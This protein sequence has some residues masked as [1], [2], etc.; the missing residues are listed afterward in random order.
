MNRSV[1]KYRR[2]ALRTLWVVMFFAFSF[3][4]ESQAQQTHTF[5]LGTNVLWTVPAGVT[6]IQVEVWGGGGR[7]STRT[8]NG[9]GGGGGG[10]AYSRSVI[11]V[12]PGQQFYYTVGTGS[13][14]NTTAGGDSYFSTSNNVSGAVVLAKGGGTVANNTTTGATG[15]QASSGVG[16]FL[17]SGGNGANGSG[18][19]GGGGGSSA[20][21]ANPGANGSGSTGGI[22]P[23]GGGNGGN[24]RTGTQGVGLPGGAP[25]GG[26]G[27]AYRTSS[28]TRNGGNGEAGRVVIQELIATETTIT[29]TGSVQEWTVPAG[30][31]KIQ[32]ETWG[33]GGR[34]GTRTSSNPA[35]GGGGGG[36]A[37]SRSVLTVIPNTTYYINVGAGGN[38]ATGAGGS[39]WFSANNN[40]SSPGALAVGGNN[41]GNVAD[42]GTGGLFS[43]GVGNIVRYSGGTGS[44]P[45]GGT[46]GGGGGSSAGPGAAG[47][48]AAANSA[49]GAA[50]PTGGGSGG[51]GM[52]GGQGPGLVG[53]I[54]GG[55]GG[56]AYRTSGTQNGGA[57][58]NGQV[59]IRVLDA[60]VGLLTTSSSMTPDIG[61]NVTLTFT[62][63]NHGPE[64][65]NGIVMTEAVPSGLVYVSHGSPSQGSVDI[66]TSTW[67]V[68][69]LANNASA[70]LS[71]TF[72]VQSSGSYSNQATVTADE[73]DLNS[74]NNTSVITLFPRVPTSNL[75]ITKEANNYTPMVGDQVT[76]TL[77]AYNS[78]P[79]NATNVLVTDQLPSGLTYQSHSGGT[80]NNING[81]WSIGSL[82]NG[83]SA[84]LTITATVAATGSYTNQATIS[85]DQFDPATN[86]NTSS[87]SVFP[88]YAPI[89]IELECEDTSYD[90]TSFADDY[91]IDNL[92]PGPGITWGWHTSSTATSGN[93][94]DAEDLVDVPTG[95][96]YLAFYDPVLGCYSLTTQ[97]TIENNCVDLGIEKTVNN[98]TPTVGQVVTFTLTLTNHGPSDATNIVIEDLIPNGY[99]NISGISPVGD[100]D[101]D[102]RTITWTVP[103]MPEGASMVFTYQAKVLAKG[104][105]ISHSN[106]ASITGLDQ[107]DHNPANDSDTLALDPRPSMLITNPM[108]RQRVTGGGD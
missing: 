13:N 94:I 80:Y 81:Q 21:T 7:G 96:Y 24:G 56:G 4:K 35:R 78:G 9:G 29:T 20:G 67:T 39:S 50:A 48:N 47:N 76:F 11:A 37:Y 12:T 75:R 18:S 66:N 68:G 107:T 91:T 92:P 77:T 101:T 54:P 55:G 72:T 71:V 6:S 53:G 79:Y 16:Q 98:P 64:T 14:N 104:D 32:V 84:A 105:G 70:T 65:A 86:N 17:F 41:V 15:G 49:T 58:A 60:D 82:A 85:G 106:T 73:L 8:D 62:V 108:I 100:W 30:V 52:S 69:A 34:G 25:G 74:S 83:A 22:A 57:G 93:K 36:G 97:V 43:A 45:T 33:G 88:T 51:N 95:T 19:N 31:T 44:T 1:G 46:I 99:T 87:I 3:V 27:G 5:N 59:R 28:M 40:G 42:G 102:T 63:T 61:S 103:S 10:G 89:T 38:A 2:M 90:L 26:G 23:S